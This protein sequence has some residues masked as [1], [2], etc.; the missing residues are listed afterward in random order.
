MT[1]V[2]D[3][4]GIPVSK[5]IK[6]SLEGLDIVVGLIRKDR[7]DARKHVMESLL[8]LNGAM[9]SCL[10]SSDMA[11]RAIMLFDGGDGSNMEGPGSIGVDVFSI[12]LIVWVD[13]NKD[14][15]EDTSYNIHIY[16]FSLDAPVNALER[17]KLLSDLDVAGLCIILNILL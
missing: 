14:C 6:A 17:M 9:R 3:G 8:L 15:F 13:E 2:E 1:T 10:D 5:K 12:V 4:C 11:S 16:N 7:T